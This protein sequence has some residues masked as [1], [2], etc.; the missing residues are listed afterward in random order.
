M[1][2]NNE[3]Q[4]NIATQLINNYD[5]IIQQCYVDIEES[6]DESRIIDTQELIDKLNLIRTAL[7]NEIVRYQKSNNTS[8]QE[9]AYTVR[10][11]VLLTDLALLYYGE[12]D[13]WQYIYDYNQLTDI[14][15]IMGQELIIPKLPDNPESS[16][17]WGD[18][19]DA[20]V[21]NRLIELDE[22]DI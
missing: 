17:H 8:Q 9:E 13:Y 21:I 18:I 6:V 12:R 14:D 16:L 5:L 20:E 2:I 3:Y 10:N 4:N 7:F 22:L 15:L 11:G 19:I 1:L